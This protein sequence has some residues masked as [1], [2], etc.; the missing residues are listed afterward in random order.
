MSGH[1]ISARTPPPGFQIRAL[2]DTDLAAAAAVS[3]AAFDLDLG[4]PSVRDR[5]RARVA[6]PLSTDPDGAFVAE[7]EGRVIG[8]AQ[9][10]LRERL[11]SL[12]LLAVQPEA[13]TT[14]AGRALLERALAY[15]AGTDA[16]LIPSSSDPRALRLYARAGFSL[17]P[18]FEATGSIDRSSLP[19]PNPDV[20]AGGSAD[21]EALSPISRD[22]RG[23]PHTLELE[24]VLQQGAQ[25]L[26]IAERGFAVAAPGHGVWLLVAYDEAAAA[27]LLWS[28]LELAGETERPSVGW[29]TAEQQ[30]AVEVVLRAGLRLVPSRALCVRGRPGPL[31]PYLPSGP[32]A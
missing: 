18:T 2:E 5:W 15:D 14:G 21:L 27:A 20:R 12:S 32:F 6:H 11:W 4:E 29:I 10:V 26:R 24:F 25:L 31:H 13:Q 22:I 9:A 30:W 7:S 23:A 17:L 28:A 19:R 8:V 16:G 1:P 3:A